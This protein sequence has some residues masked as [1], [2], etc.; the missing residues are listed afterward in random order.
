MYVVCVDM[1]SILCC[2]HVHVCACYTCRRHVLTLVCHILLASVNVVCIVH[3]HVTCVDVKY[4]KL[5]AC[6]NVVCIVCVH[7]HVYIEM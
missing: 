6:V 1:C 2:V 7:V 4:V 5:V 3:V